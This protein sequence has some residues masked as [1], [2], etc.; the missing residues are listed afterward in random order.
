MP[1]TQEAHT[2]VENSDSESDSCIVSVNVTRCISLSHWASSRCV[3]DGN[4]QVGLAEK[5]TGALRSV[6]TDLM[7]NLQLL[8]LDLRLVLVKARETVTLM[9]VPERTRAWR[10]E[11]GIRAS[12]SEPARKLQSWLCS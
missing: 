4:R 3:G 7:F 9:H 5:Y 12:A 1:S 10:G 8:G 6:G 11:T 2:P